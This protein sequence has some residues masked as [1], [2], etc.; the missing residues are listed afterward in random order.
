VRSIFG[1]VPG[2][3]PYV[4]II[5]Y[6]DVVSFLKSSEADPTIRIVLIAIRVESEYRSVAISLSELGPK[7]EFDVPIAAESKITNLL[8]RLMM[9]RSCSCSFGLVWEQEPRPVP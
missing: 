3:D 1:G 5:S 6:S 9:T 7:G 4:L 2:G 8:R